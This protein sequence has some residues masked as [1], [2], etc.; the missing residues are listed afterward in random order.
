MK[1]FVLIEIGFN[2]IH[3]C[4]SKLKRISDEE[5]LIKEVNKLKNPLWWFV[6]DN[7]TADVTYPATT[8][9]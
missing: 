2:G 3:P 8:W 5:T 4:K 1:R 6:I 7:E 9:R